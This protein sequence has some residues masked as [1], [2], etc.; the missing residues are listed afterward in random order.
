[1]PTMTTVLLAI[2]VFGF[3]ALV[4]GAA[5]GDLAAMTIPNRIPAGLVVFAAT[6]GLFAA[7]L[8]GGGDA[9]LMPAVALWLGPA[10]VGPF[11]MATAVTGGILA[12][13]F[14]VLRRLP[15]PTTAAGRPWVARLMSPEEGIP[16]GV[17]IAAGALV[18]IGKAPILLALAG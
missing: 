8:F 6:A 18:S 7:G 13:A 17:A 10:A 1:M 14:L 11:V 2:A 3:F 15:V 12:V 16:Y 9:K 4:I 5:L